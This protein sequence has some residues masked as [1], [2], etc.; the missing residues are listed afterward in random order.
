MKIISNDLRSSCRSLLLGAYQEGGGTKEIESDWVYPEEWPA[1]PNAG[2]GEAVLLI[3][4]WENHSKISLC[5]YT[6]FNSQLPDGY[7]VTIDWGDGEVLYKTTFSSTGEKI[8]HEYSSEHFGQYIFIRFFSPEFHVPSGVEGET[9][10][11]FACLAGF[12]STSDGYIK[13]VLAACVG[14]R[15]VSYETNL[16]FNS[17]YTRFLTNDFNETTMD[18]FKCDYNSD[19]QKYSGEY[20]NILYTYMDKYSKRIDFVYPPE[21]LGGYRLP[22]WNTL[23]TVTGLDKLTALGKTYFFTNCYALRKISLPELAELTEGCFGSDYSLEEVYMPKC[24][25]ICASALS[26]CWSLR[27]VTVSAECEIDS[28]ALANN[29]QYVEIIREGST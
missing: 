1:L 23:R 28:T 24:T 19:S 27:K 26:N 10:R 25:K 7:I 14:N 4:P 22:S 21:Y 6:T 9:K 20:R 11:I 29:Y 2:T 15:S 17:I 18:S 8:E 5:I 16:S 3:Q 13:N 12:G